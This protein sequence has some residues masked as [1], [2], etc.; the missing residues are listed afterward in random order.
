MHTQ[1]CI[2]AQLHECSYMYVCTHT[3]T[4]V[5]MHRRVHMMH[6]R[7]VIHVNTCPDVGTHMCAC[8][9]TSMYTPMLM[10]AH[11][12]TM[13]VH[14]LAHAQVDT[15]TQTQECACMWT[16]LPSVHTPTYMHPCLCM[17]A[18][19]HRPCSPSSSTVAE[20]RQ[21]PHLS[22]PDPALLPP[23]QLLNAQGSYC[24]EKVDSV[25]C[26]AGGDIS[27]TTWYPAQVACKCSQLFS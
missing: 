8:L 5:Q 12:C 9:H 17:H 19:T 4:H 20:P 3:H 2:H 11:L 1:T 15:L 14:T 13:H 23:Q 10:C 21:N 16:L 25:S 24:Q 22:I 18:R 6:P 7:G 26:R 27:R